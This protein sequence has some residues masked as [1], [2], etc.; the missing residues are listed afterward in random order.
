MISLLVHVVTFFGQLYFWRSYF[1]AFLQ[2]NYFDTTFTFRSGYFFRAAELF[3]VELLLC[4]SYYFQKATFLERNFYRVASSCEQV[5]LQNSYFVATDTFLMKELVQKKNIYRRATFLKQV[6]LH[7]NNFFRTATFLT[8]VLFQ[9]KYFFKTATFWKQLIF[10][11][12]NIPHYLLLLKSHSFKVGKTYH[13]MADTF[14]EELLCK[15][16][17]FRRGTIS[18]VHFLST[19]HFLFI[20]QQLSELDTSFVK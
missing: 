14:L 13:S 6:L 9:K 10:Q 20:S 19:A 17:F 11:K 18:E 5:V 16:Y 15:T 4:S 3:F 1:F 2:S 8:K 7:S 12:I